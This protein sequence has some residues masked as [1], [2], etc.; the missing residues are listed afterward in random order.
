MD[1]KTQEFLQKLKDIGHLNDDYDYSKVKYSLSSDKVI[2]IDKKFGS[3]H[4]ITPQKLINKN[5][6]CTIR[7]CTN[8]NQYL[9]NEFKAVHGDKYNY[10]KVEYNGAKNDII[11][12]C[13]KH[14][15]FKQEASSHKLGQ[16]CPKCSGKNKSS[17]EIIKEFKLIHGETFN[18]SKVDYVNSK[19]GVIITCRI[20]GD[21][22]QTPQLH[23]LNKRPCP[24]CK[25][26]IRNTDEFLQKLKDI[27][28]L[29]CLN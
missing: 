28:Q 14:G 5:T 9:I 7:N 11:V 19:T 15:E 20:H 1:R 2:V 8:K 3:E 27:G 12:I 6:L 21:F 10:S 24:K 4:L 22:K 18:Y 25:G 17:E 29:N 26:S 23:L 13:K 16:G